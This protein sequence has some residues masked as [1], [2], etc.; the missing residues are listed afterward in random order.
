MANSKSLPP[1][2]SSLTSSV[3]AFIAQLISARQ[4]SD[5]TLLVAFS[6]GLDSSVLLHLL[7]NLQA[8]LRFRLAVMHVHHGLSANA[9]SWAEF[10]RT[11]CNQY[12]LDC[13]V[14]SV[15]VN[16]AN[17]LGIEA[18]ARF[19][20][21]QALNQA[22]ADYIALAHHQ[23]DQAETFMLQLAR[24]AGVKG[25]AAMARVDESKR[26]IRPLLDVSRET[27]EAYAL[28][29]GLSWIEDE[30]N[31]DKRFARNAMRHDVLPAIANYYPAIPKTLA[32]TANHMAEASELLDDL[33]KLDA[34][35]ML[36][37]SVYSPF[38]T[39]NLH[40]L[41]A[42]SSARANNVL[43]FWLAKYAILMPNAEHLT[44]L[45]QQLLTAAS[46]ANV[47]VHISP[48]LSVRRYLGVACLVRDEP[49][50]DFQPITW[51]GESSLEL[52]FGKM[53]FTHVMGQGLSLNL[54]ASKPLSIQL[55]KGGETL[56]P[57]NN[58]PRR[59]LKYLLQQAAVPAW[60]RAQWPLVLSGTQLICV[61]NVADEANLQAQ[62]NEMGLLIEWQATV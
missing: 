19:A 58:R 29:H 2:N 36:Q 62:S 61:P 47:K 57:A 18:A 11:V 43:R 51:Q 34:Q 7:V 25:L 38:D 33:A 45:R 15:S 49:K 40:A 56:Q 20:R 50:F 16:K 28:A 12:G 52:G 46:S 42:L 14:A 59:S 48:E 17:G 13:Q 9:D 55:R 35:G 23:D 41:S 1:N 27:I 54:L 37:P 6:G 4:F 31:A 10:C 21:Y 8:K 3:H 30:S 24:G 32:R 39:L 53:T 44:Q 22:Q 60:L 26:L 5:T